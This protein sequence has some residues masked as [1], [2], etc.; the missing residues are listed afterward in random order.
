MRKTG[1]LLAIVVNAGCTHAINVRAEPVGVP[2]RVTSWVTSIRYNRSVFVGE[3]HIRN[4]SADA[5]VLT[6]D[7]VSCWRGN[8]QGRVQIVG[9]E[10]ANIPI[11]FL[12]QQTRRIQLICR[13][14]GRKGDFRIV[15]RS[16]YRADDR[17]E[18]GKLFTSNLV[19]AVNKEG[20]TALP[21]GV[22]QT[23]SVDASEGPKVPPTTD[24]DKFSSSLAPRTS[25]GFVAGPGWVVAVM[26][27]DD[28]NSRSARLR[29]DR[30][31]IRNIGDQLRIFVAQHGVRTVDKSSTER[32]LQDVVKTLKSESYG[33][34]Y[35]DACQIE[36]GKALAATHILRSQITR[37]GSKCVLNAELIDLRSEVA[38]SAASARGSCGPEGFLG[39]CE[40][41]A[42]LVTKGDAGGRE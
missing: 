13:D 31:L 37:F 5:L 29:I 18:K 23:E 19:I 12:P 4:E 30:D 15:L 14:I 42:A 35:D 17:G 6:A 1:F 10:K 11:N 25:R 7:D 22:G 39:M 16:V 3:L 34:C 24:A 40:D 26:A 41:V 21:P 2:G 32:A 28:V 38:V 9:F 36:L 20:K 8:T 27:V 33:V